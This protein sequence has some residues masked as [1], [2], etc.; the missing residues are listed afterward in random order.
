VITIAGSPGSTMLLDFDLTQSF[1]P[2]PPGSKMLSAT[3]F[4]LCPKVRAVELEATGELRGTVS[5]VVGD[6]VVLVEKANVVVM[7]TGEIPENAITTTAS[8]TG[9]AF[10]AIG[11]EPGQYDVLVETQ[12]LR[13]F[14]KGLSVQVGQATTADITIR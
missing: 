12:D 9:G 14:V 11:L 2:M 10:A 5:T 13:G 4:E 7:P 6:K 3:S 8:S 1:T